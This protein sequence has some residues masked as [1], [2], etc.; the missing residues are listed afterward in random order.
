MI[1]FLLR[2]LVQNFPIGRALCPGVGPDCLHDFA[3][4]DESEALM[5]FRGR[6]RIGSKAR[7]CTPS[8]FKLRLPGCYDRW[9][10]ETNL[11]RYAAACGRKLVPDLPYPAYFDARLKVAK[12]L[13][14]VRATRDCDSPRNAPHS[15]I[16]SSP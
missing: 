2:R 13:Q 1:R 6:A 5:S 9:Q 11:T 12:F 10:R 7:T 14:L 16:R 8:S 3:L 4:L 15:A